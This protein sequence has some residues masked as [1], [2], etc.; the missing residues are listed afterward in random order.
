MKKELCIRLVIYKDITSYLQK[1]GK[2]SELPGELQIYYV[3]L[4]EKLKKS[5]LPFNNHYIC[6]WFSCSLR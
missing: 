6:M 4:A 5:E 1:S 3:I 2:K